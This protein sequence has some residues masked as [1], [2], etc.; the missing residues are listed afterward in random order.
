L[1]PEGRGT[2]IRDLIV[3][4]VPFGARR[5]QSL[6]AENSPT[7]GSRYAAWSIRPRS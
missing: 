4:A 7:V 1:L 2:T 5:F 3:A 6:C